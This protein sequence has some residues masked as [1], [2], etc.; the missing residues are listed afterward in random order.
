[1]APDLAG[2]VRRCVSTDRGREGGGLN[3]G[4]FEG[5]EGEEEDGEL[6]SEHDGVVYVVVFVYRQDRGWSD[7]GG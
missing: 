7:R 3:D 4:G 5:G 2:E 1:M 6:G